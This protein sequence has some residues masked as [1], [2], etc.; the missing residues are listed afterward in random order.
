MLQKLDMIQENIVKKMS[1]V[2]LVNLDLSWKDLD[3]FCNT[4]EVT[5][6]ATLLGPGI[7]YIQHNN[8]L[9]VC[10]FLAKNLT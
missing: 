1:K 8:I 9:E 2:K 4:Q 5:N 7:M 3:D 10:M 6:F